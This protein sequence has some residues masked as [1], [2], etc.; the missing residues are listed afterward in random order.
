MEQ[1]IKNRLISKVQA[2][3]YIKYSGSAVT[4]L[5]SPT[6]VMVL[7]I[8]KQK[9]RYRQSTKSSSG[10]RQHVQPVSPYIRHFA[11]FITLKLEKSNPIDAR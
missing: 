7:E 10:R 9:P 8:R 1:F 4:G 2:A 6:V 11:L 5:D 3:T